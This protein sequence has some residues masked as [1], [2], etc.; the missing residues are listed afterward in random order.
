MAGLQN[1]LFEASCLYWYTSPVTL[2]FFSS[3]CLF[4]QSSPDMSLHSCLL[5]TPEIME[6]HQSIMKHIFICPDLHC[7]DQ[8]CW[9]LCWELPCTG[10]LPA[11]CLPVDLTVPSDLMFLLSVPATNVTF[12]QLGLL[13]GIISSCWSQVTSSVTSYTNPFALTGLVT[14]FSAYFYF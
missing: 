14:C 9:S 2:I 7:R 13:K 6:G 4:G 8:A 12:C 11:R 5:I 1:P 3:L 10:V